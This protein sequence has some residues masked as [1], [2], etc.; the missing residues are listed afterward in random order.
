VLPTRIRSTS[1]SAA[2]LLSLVACEAG[3]PAPD[4]GRSTA[5]VTTASSAST[6]A[7]PTPAP[8]CADEQIT[9]GKIRRHDEV[10]HVSSVQVITARTGGPVDAPLRSVRPYTA[11]VTA[12]GQVPEDR[13]Y[14][15]FGTMAADL[16]DLPPL[17]ETYTPD[18][19]T[20]QTG[21]PGRVIRYEGVGAV[22]A[23]FNYRCGSVVIRGLV[24]SWR[25]PVS[26]LL[27]CN[28][29]PQWGGSR[30]AKQAESHACR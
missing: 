9:F 2:A 15:K 28:L 12:D 25:I 1:L 29:G 10:T 6:L 18:Q 17:G 4:P 26:G 21:S 19:G 14:E 7:T 22:D 8:T 20:Y 24:T 13:V 16:D 5:A 3:D 11:Q 30:I 27:D 23:P